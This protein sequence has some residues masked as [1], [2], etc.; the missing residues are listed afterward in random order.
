[1]K[2]RRRKKRKHS[3]RPILVGV[4]LALVIFGVGVLVRPTDSK[5]TVQTQEQ[6]KH[7]EGFAVKVD[8]SKVECADEESDAE[9]EIIYV[10][11]NQA[12]PQSNFGIA[13]DKETQRKNS[14]PDAPKK[15]KRQGNE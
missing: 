6:P 2:K 9:P 7:E 12:H 4:G 8:L 3:K 15:P 1:M 14:A 11:E 13:V 5:T 10:K